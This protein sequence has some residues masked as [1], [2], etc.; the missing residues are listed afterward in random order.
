MGKYERIAIFLQINFRS[1]YSCWCAN[2]TKV[3]VVSGHSEYIDAD[4]VAK[5][6]QGQRN[7]VAPVL[8][9]VASKEK[10]K[11]VR[12]EKKIYRFSMSRYANGRDWNMLEMYSE[13]KMPMTEMNQVLQIR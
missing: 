11:L 3:N 4:N 5:K 6:M 8:A 10:L 7:E 12:Y 2:E 9:N 1:L 13:T